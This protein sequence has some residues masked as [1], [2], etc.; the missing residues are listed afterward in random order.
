MESECC[1]DIPKEKWEEKTVTWRNKPFYK[2]KV[3][4][5]FHFPIRFESSLRSAGKDIKSKG[6]EFARPVM[7]IE[8][9]SNTFSQEM[10]MSLDKIYPDPNVVT[11]TGTFM[12]K[13]FVGPYKDMKDYIK[14]M[15][16]F[17]EEKGL[18]AKELLFWYTNCPEC[19][20]KQGG[21]KTVILAK[22]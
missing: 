13:M 2:F 9:G 12:S 1:P 15:N 22:V 5:L 19:A 6:M 17:V 10:L 14:E 18:H 8:R 11:L 4:S 3:R 7:V 20:K 16:S 21:P